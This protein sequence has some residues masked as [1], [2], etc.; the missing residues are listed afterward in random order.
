[1]KVK[2]S[3]SRDPLSLFKNRTPFVTYRAQQKPWLHLVLKIKR[4]I[5]ES[6]L[7]QLQAAYPLEACGLLAG[8]N[9]IATRLY[10]IDN[11]LQSPTAYEMDPLQQVR[12]L[13][14]IETLGQVLLAIY[15]S[16]PQGPQT[17][18]AT[19]VAQAYYPEAIYIIVSF[20][21]PSEPAVRAFTIIDARVSEISWMVV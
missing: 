7:E 5:Y 17:P 11:I 14:E 19:D 10:A 16:H 1:M 9:D 20:A 4:P 6:M 15:H 12:A 2:G 3:R 18:S 13:L 21:D 8:A